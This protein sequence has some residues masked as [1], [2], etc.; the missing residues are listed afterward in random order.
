MVSKWLIT[1]PFHSYRPGS[2][3]WIIR[4]WNRPSR[5]ILYPLPYFEAR[6]RFV[7]RANLLISQCSPCTEME[8]QYVPYRKAE[9]ML[10]TTS[11]YEALLM[12]D[13]A[14]WRDSVSRLNMEIA[15]KT[16]ERD[17]LAK[18]ISAAETLVGEGA[19]DDSPESDLSSLRS[20]VKEL[21]EDGQVRKPRHIRHSLRPRRRS[22][23]H[24]QHIRQ[25]LQCHCAPL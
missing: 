12:K 24:Q 25:F 1:H 22:E 10:D 4:R 19:D 6:C 16:K 20:A 9:T 5:H 14:K 3:E 23:T 17:D 13:L 2:L 18:K 7:R 8:I 15:A 21:M 11:G